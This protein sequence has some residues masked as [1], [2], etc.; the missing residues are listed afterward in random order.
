MFLDYYNSFIKQLK[1]I[2]PDAN[3]TEILTQVE[4]ENDD[5]KKARGLYFAGLI[6]EENFDLFLK[7]KIK[8]FSHKNELNKQLSESLFNE[9][10][11]LKS[12]LNNQPDDIKKIIWSYLHNLYL[13][14]NINDNDKIKRLNEMLEDKNKDVKDKLHDIFGNDIN[15]QTTNMIDDIVNSFEQILNNSKGNPLSGILNISQQISSKYAD[16]INS[17]EIELNKL[18]GS[19]TKTMPNMPTNGEMP[20]ITNIPGMEG[21]GDMMK[22][23]MGSMGPMMGSMNPNQEKKSEEKVIID[24]N[25]STASV[26]VGKLEENKGGMKIGSMLKMADGLGVIPGGKKNKNNDNDGLGSLM[27]NLMNNNNMSNNIN[28]DDI[29]NLMPQF[30]KVMNVLQKLDGNGEAD[31][32]KLKEEMDALLENDFGI[33]M[34]DKID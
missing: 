21:L 33:N 20:D 18:M 34:K 2:F 6:D 1:I 25:F 26:D 29:N 24:E 14:S 31:M 7:S 9:N 23:M 8:V 17:G 13:H 12:M 5:S 30:G 27:S 3:V 15:S 28:E 22:N 10:L 4:N 32:D 16:K 19:I 11:S